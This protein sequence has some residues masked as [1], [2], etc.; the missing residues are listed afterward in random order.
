MSLVKEGCVHFAKHLL[1]FICIFIVANP[2]CIAPHAQLRI[3]G[4]E[5]YSPAYKALK[6]GDIKFFDVIT[7]L[8]E[9]RVTMGVLFRQ[10]TR[11]KTRPEL[12]LKR[13]RNTP[14][15]KTLLTK[16]ITLMA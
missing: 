1:S 16:G 3:L 9:E 2:S 8:N 14:S 4:V 10:N 6:E 13:N 11:D 12:T 15:I 7:E 5:L